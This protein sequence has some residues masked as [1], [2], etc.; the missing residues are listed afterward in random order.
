MMDYVIGFNEEKHTY[1]FN[2]VSV[3]SVTTILLEEGFINAQFFT[4]EGRD[5]GKAIHRMVENHCRGAHCLKV[6]SF[7]PYMQAFKNFEMDCDWSPSIIEQPFACEQ[8]AGTVDQIGT[9]GKKPAIID[10]KTGIISAATGLQLAAYEKLYSFYRKRQGA[11]IIGPM[12]RI[13]VQ[14]TDTGRYILTEYKDR[15]DAFIWDSA[16]AIHTWK[17]NNIKR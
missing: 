10:I 5:R 15:R 13:A 14:L 12:H 7:E 11:L 2:G 9:L 17:K 8:Y 6:P 1:T 16:V 4:T 3:P